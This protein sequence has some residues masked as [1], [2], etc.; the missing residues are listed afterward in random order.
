MKIR[1]KLFLV[2]KCCVGSTDVCM[3][4]NANVFSL[5]KRVYKNLNVSPDV[6]CRIYRDMLAQKV[7]HLFYGG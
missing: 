3:L 6:P 1:E 4:G 7:S 2:G 5:R